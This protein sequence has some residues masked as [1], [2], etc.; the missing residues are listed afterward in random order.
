MDK[1][2][3]YFNK[4]I[5]TLNMLFVK[6]G[7]GFMA[8]ECQGCGCSIPDGSKYCRNCWE[9]ELLKYE[10]AKARYQER[11]KEWNSLSEEEKAKRNSEATVS[12]KKSTRTKS[13]FICG[14]I[15]FFIGLAVGSGASSTAAAAPALGI[16]F[17]ILFGVLGNEIGKGIGGKIKYSAE[18][19]PPV[20]PSNRGGK[21]KSNKGSLS[22][23]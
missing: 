23:N 8:Y 21:P 19:K 10:E 14:G 5:F 9:E 16:I 1:Y 11:L 17:A 12:G 7:G 22:L 20:M 15:G 4:F 2:G 6:G 18:P 3:I 13:I